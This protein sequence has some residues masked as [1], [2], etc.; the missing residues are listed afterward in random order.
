MSGPILVTVHGKRSKL[1]LKVGVFTTYS[2]A[3]FGDTG[4]NYSAKCLVTRIVSHRR[5]RKGEHTIYLDPVSN[6]GTKP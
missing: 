4:P 1:G 6:T 3:P 2:F 5:R